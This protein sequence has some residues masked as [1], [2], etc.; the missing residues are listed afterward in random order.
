MNGLTQQD[1]VMVAGSLELAR[2]AAV[3]QWGWRHIGPGE[4]RRADGLRVRYIASLEGLRALPRGA[5][6]FLGSGWASSPA[7]TSKAGREM[8]ARFTVAKTPDQAVR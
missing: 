5:V 4:F 1:A 8:L 3:E 2:H 6:L 7:I